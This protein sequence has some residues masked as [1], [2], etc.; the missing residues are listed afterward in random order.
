MRAFEQ[1][2]KNTS[3]SSNSSFFSPKIQKKLKTGTP[4]DQ[5][6]VEADKV[7]DKVVNNNSS[8]ALLQSKS[9]EEV[10]QKPISETISSV[11][12]KEMKEE[13]PVQKKSDEKEEK[14]QKKEEEKEPIQK[15]EKEE[16]KGPIQKK[17]KEE[18]KP[19]QKKEEKKEEEPVQKKEEKEEP[20]QAKCAD[21]EKEEKVQKKEVKEEEKPVQK[22]EE[23]S[24][25]ESQE[26]ELEGK[27]NSS[28]GGGKGLDKKTK[29]EME[30]GF[31]AD[32]SDVKVHTDSNAVQMSQ[33][34]GAQA[35]TNGNDV[36]FN[37]GKYN[38]N[39]KEGKHLLAHELTHTIQQNGAKQKSGMVQKSTVGNDYENGSENLEAPRFQGN[40]ILEQVH[41]NQRLVGNGQSGPCVSKIQAG[42]EDLGFT[43]PQYG[44][45]GVF[46]NE[47]KQAVLDFQDTYDLAYDGIVGGETMGLLDDIHAGKQGGGGKK[48]KKKPKKCSKKK[49]VVVKSG[50]FPSQMSTKFFTESGCKNDIIIKSRDLHDN[51]DVGGCNAFEIVVDGINRGTVNPKFGK[52]TTT[53]VSI[54]GISIG[55]H[56]ITLTVP[57]Y[58][59]AIIKATI[60]VF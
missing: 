57:S 24:N 31:G 49:P 60:S 33:E 50:T 27:L 10:Q 42:L 56:E 40:S 7:A 43:L 34:L 6:E 17:E 4:G 22:K 2:K 5:F 37:K 19:V 23:N 38:P 25:K 14:V 3:S 30:S 28:K 47:T 11:Q 36:Y 54:P 58:C 53:V 21:C 48:D 29:N 35:F 52:D 26:N 55:M 45:D 41:D 15:K 1:R 44:A 39:S 20:I 18:E 16:E 9:E 32:F 59:N 13:E 8:G 51:S 46:G 12:S